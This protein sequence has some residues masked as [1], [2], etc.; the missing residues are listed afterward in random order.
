[1]N[2]FVRCIAVLPLIIGAAAAQQK[3]SAAAGDEAALKAIEEKWD[4]ASVKGDTQA[5]GAI[6]ADPF[7]STNVDGVVRTKA[8][9]LARMKAGEVKYL[10]SKVDNMKVIVSGDTAVVT[11]R[12]AGKF[13]EKGKTIN[14]TERF[15]DTFVRQGGT[16]RCIASHAS[17]LK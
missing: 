12:W 17:T 10:N 13:V 5:L 3:S 1:M 4:I 9:M 8:E 16:W 6:W 14:A 7:V 11:G 15:T 2:Q